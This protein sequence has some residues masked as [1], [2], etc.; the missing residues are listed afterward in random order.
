MWV[1]MGVYGPISK[2]CRELFGRSWGLSVGCGMTLGALEGTLMCQGSL[3]S[4]V[5][6][7][8]CRLQ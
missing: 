6:E 8:G 1:F 2:R 7:G 5:E 4:V 3:V